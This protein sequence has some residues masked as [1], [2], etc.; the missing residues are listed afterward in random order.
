MRILKKK[1]YEAFSLVEMLITIV[2]IGIV[3]LIASVTLTTLIKISTVSSNKTRVRNETEFV[4]E[5][6]RRTV[7]NSNPADVMIYNSLDA[8]M[9]DSEN[10]I[11]VNNP[12]IADMSSIYST[13]LDENVSGNE[14][15]FKPYGYANW[16]CI[17][18][19]RDIDPEKQLGYILKTSTQDLWSSAQKC[20]DGTTED[21]RMYTIELN[22]KDVDINSF[23]ITYTKSTEGNY[24]IRFDL[25]AEPVSWYLAK[26]APVNRE[27]F[28]QAVVSTEG[29]NW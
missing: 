21:Y 7:R 12:A 3:M 4:L 5:L 11:V 23:N 27:V 29:I 26:G 10:G 8:R 19:F 17:G 25:S 1:K 28:R 20:F 14:I 9:F 24:I 22:S 18:F 16:M 2:I 6:V 13:P 15:H